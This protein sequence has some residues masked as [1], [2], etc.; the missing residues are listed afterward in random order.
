MSHKLQ[1]MATKFDTSLVEWK[2]PIESSNICAQSSS[3]LHHTPA[4]ESRKDGNVDKSSL[5]ARSSIE[6]DA[7]AMT[8]DD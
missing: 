5:V 6:S 8:V 2:Q 3:Q 4:P 1:Q 7:D